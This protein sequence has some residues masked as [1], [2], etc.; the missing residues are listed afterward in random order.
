MKQGPA[1]VAIVLVAL[2]T[3]CFEE[4]PVVEPECRTDLDC[5][6]KFGPH[7]LCDNS[8]RCQEACQPSCEAL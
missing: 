2:A 7:F 5:L 1:L 4:S 8:H 6:A 3:G